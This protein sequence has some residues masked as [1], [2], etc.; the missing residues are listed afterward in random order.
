M[1][2]P[3]SKEFEYFWRVYPKR[4]SKSRHEWIK[5]R[6]FPAWQSWEKLSED[7]Q[8]HLLALGKKIKQSEGDYPRDAVVWLNQR[9]WDDMDLP[10]SW[11]PALPA[12]L[13]KDALKSAEI[14]TVDFNDERN[15]QMRALK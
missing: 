12:E 15:R 7:I 2:K 13:T 3:Y 10:S 1:T 5:R 4:W 6:K 8:L 9:G 11:V 14:K